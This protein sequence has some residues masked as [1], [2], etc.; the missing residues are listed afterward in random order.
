MSSTRRLALMAVLAALGVAASFI[1]NIPIPLLGTKVYPFQALIN[2]LGAV[3][4]GPW[5]AAGVALVV[6]LVR[7]TLGTGSILA[8]PGSIIGA[9]LAGCL[10]LWT[11]RWWTALLGEL[12]GTGLIAALVAYPVG[13]YILHKKVAA[14]AYVVPFSLASLSGVVLAAVITPLLLRVPA[15]GSR[16]PAAR[17]HSA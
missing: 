15:I 14:F 17:R 7:I 2:V 8:I 1:T 9:L 10:V 13:V 11:G 6:A 5:E 12:V 3:L 4:L 16:A